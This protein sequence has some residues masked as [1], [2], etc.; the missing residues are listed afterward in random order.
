MLGA[1][2]EL[3]GP[4]GSGTVLV[5][6]EALTVGSEGPGEPGTVVTRTFLGA[7]TRL[8]VATDAGE[9]T[10]DAATRPGLPEPGEH[11]VVRLDTKRVR[12][13]G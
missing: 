4:P 13:A 9:V 7:V 11:T 6:P 5:R 3:D 1:S 10:V 2:T 12:A 8:V